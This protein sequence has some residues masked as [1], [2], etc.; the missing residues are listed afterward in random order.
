MT[1]LWTLSRLA[2]FAFVCYSPWPQ[3]DKSSQLKA[4]IHMMRIEVDE[5]VAMK[6]QGL[7]RQ[8]V[9]QVMYEFDLG[10]CQLLEFFYASCHMHF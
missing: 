3:H 10:C 2:H 1:Q 6:L 9:M 5:L 7:T 8:Q 4:A